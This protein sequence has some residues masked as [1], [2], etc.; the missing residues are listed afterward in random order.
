MAVLQINGN[1]STE[2]E[3]SDARFSAVELALGTIEGQI[4]VLNEAW[5]DEKSAKFITELQQY[6]TDIKSKV[7]TAKSSASDVFDELYKCLNIYIN[8]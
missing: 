4:A 1:F 8:K 7:T 2:K 3:K 5:Q 6:L